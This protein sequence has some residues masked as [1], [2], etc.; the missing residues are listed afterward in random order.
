MGIDGDAGARAQT[1]FQV[2]LA[3]RLS[4]MGEDELVDK[5][6]F[7]S[8]LYQLTA[9]KSVFFIIPA[10]FIFASVFSKPEW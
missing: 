7:V 6:C 5:N 9:K 2:A 3:R 1:G 10:Y 4:C 8:V